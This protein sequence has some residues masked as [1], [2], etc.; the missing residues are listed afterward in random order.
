M[1]G[2][3]IQVKALLSMFTP[4]KNY[5]AL[6]SKTN[7]M[8]VQNHH[9]SAIDKA[10]FGG[11]EI[12]KD[13]IA[14][15]LGS[16]T[17][18]TES[19]G[20]VPL[21]DNGRS[22]FSNAVNQYRQSRYVVQISAAYRTPAGEGEISM[23]GFTDREEFLGNALPDDMIIT[24]NSVSI[25]AVGQ[26]DN[27][28]PKREQIYAGRIQGNQ[29]LN[30][31]KQDGNQFGGF[32]RQM[33]GNGAPPMQHAD[34]NTLTTN[35][36]A[37]SLATEAY[38]DDPH[39]PRDSLFINMDDTPGQSNRAKG[40][41]FRSNSSADVVGNVLCGY[42]QETRDQNT[43]W[44]ASRGRFVE[45]ENEMM[46]GQTPMYHRWL[47]ASQF[48]AEGVLSGNR[49]MLHLNDCVP[50]FLNNGQISW[51]NLKRIFGN[52]DQITEIMNVDF[53]QE[54]QDIFNI[55]DETENLNARRI[56]ASLADRIAELVPGVVATE[57]YVRYSFM[58]TNR[59]NDRRDRVTTLGNLDH[60]HLMRDPQNLNQTNEKT[61]NS[62]CRY[63]G[64]VLSDGGQRP[65]E[66]EVHYAF[67]ADMRIF[68]NMGSG[69]RQYI[70]ANFPDRYANSA[71]S[72]S[73][74]S[75]IEDAAGNVKGIA[76]GLG[77]NPNGNQGQASMGSMQEN[78][79]TSNSWGKPQPMTNTWG[80]NTGM[81]SVSKKSF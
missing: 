37:S 75:D 36:I 53:H 30:P 22:T 8:T 46:G 70:R 2:S 72:F 62:L 69:R 25:Y 59:T 64:T 10:T 12:N 7:K 19:R 16:A 73:A 5:Q 9:L 18:L 60:P 81:P 33:G 31:V 79:T 45:N 65:Y 47:T 20:V 43:K 1:S 32:T 41:S 40:T 77:V 24:F 44:E 76:E 4:V 68:I 21:V 74:R 71:V 78:F 11:N 13:T 29:P 26:Y 63:L 35:T 55:S 50:T 54:M 17:T 38:Y 34:Y 61:N 66:I 6:H 23:F 58:M 42:V 51:G 27:G 56:E 3:P 15:I 14:P 48:G 67:R 28:M 57:G 80:S 52:I 39:V 49:L